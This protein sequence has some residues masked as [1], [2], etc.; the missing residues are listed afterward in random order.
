M[1]DWKPYVVQGKLH[2]MP[3]L[4]ASCSRSVRW[5]LSTHGTPGTEGDG[6]G[7]HGR[8]SIVDRVVVLLTVPEV[9]QLVAIGNRADPVLWVNPLLDP[10]SGYMED[11]D[12]PEERSLYGYFMASFNFV[13]AYDPAAQPLRQPGVLSP[14]SSQAKA[15][16]LYNDFLTALDGLDDIPTD[17]DGA[18]FTAGAASLGTAFGEVDAAF[19]TITDP[20]GDGTWRDLSRTLDTFTNAAN[21]FIDAAREIEDSVGALSHQIQTAPLLIR[22]VVGDAVANLKAPAGVVASFI[23]KGPSDLYSMMLDAGVEVT[24]ANIVALME[25]NGITDPL[26]IAPALTIAI[27]VPRV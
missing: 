24:E 12:I 14:A 19:D 9:A 3:L 10:V 11:L 17:S 4:V 23:T 15:G 21:S 20:A 5:R 7:K 13:E 6:K 25:D 16:N 2:N 27:P 1:S 26:F 18:A 8:E 22:E